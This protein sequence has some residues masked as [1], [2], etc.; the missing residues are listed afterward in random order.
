MKYDFYFLTES[1]IAWETSILKVKQYKSPS[2][3]NWSSFLL[4][5]RQDSANLLAVFLLLI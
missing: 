4:G 3:P 5:T 2:G 1:P